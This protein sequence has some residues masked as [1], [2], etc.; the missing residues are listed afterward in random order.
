MTGHDP[1][2]D[3]HHRIVAMEFVGKRDSV[4]VSCA[5]GYVDRIASWW[6]GLPDGWYQPQA[7]DFMPAMR[8][9]LD[10]WFRAS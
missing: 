7:P 2:H 4:G 5:C 1:K 8:L 9:F 3:D 6:D 10:S